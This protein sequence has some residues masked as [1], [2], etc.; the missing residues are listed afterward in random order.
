MKKRP[1]E[2]IKQ[3]R[4][5]Q[6]VLPSGCF[7]VR[8]VWCVKTRFWGFDSPSTNENDLQDIDGKQYCPECF[9]QAECKCENMTFDN[10]A[11]CF[12]CDDCN[13]RKK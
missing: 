10:D 6:P 1:L 8:Y 11:G 4:G 9:E 2:R 12:I 5:T 7:P 3:S 13:Q